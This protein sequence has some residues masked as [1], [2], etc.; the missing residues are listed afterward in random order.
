MLSNPHLHVVRAGNANG[1]NSGG[2][3]MKV[4]RFSINQTDPGVVREVF[5]RFSVDGCGIA[6]CNCSPK[7]F[8]SFSDGKNGISIEL[9]KEEAESFIKDVANGWVDFRGKE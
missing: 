7:R 8:L 2:N 5:V 3:K 4:N 1:D 9:T 6:G